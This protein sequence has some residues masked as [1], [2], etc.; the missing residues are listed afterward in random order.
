MTNAANNPLHPKALRYL[1]A[2]AQLGSVQA[3]ARE[4]SI[5]ASAIDRQILL[6]EQDLGVPLFERLPR[7]MRPTAAGE[8][9]LALSQRWK[10]DLNRTLSDI[11][12][13]QG[14]NQGQLR[15][16][17]MDSHANGLL[18]EFVHTVHTEYPGVELD[19]EIVNTDDAV[20]HL[21]AGDV[22]LL[23][24]FNL[25]ASRDLHIVATADLPL[26]CV[27]APQHPLASQPHLSFRD[28]AAWPLAAQSRALAIRRYLDR[29]HHWLLE[30]ARPPLVTNS[31]QLVKRLACSGTHVALTSELDAGPEILDGSLRFVPVL[32]KSALAQTVAVAIS[33][34]RPLSRVARIVAERLGQHVI[35]YLARVRALTQPDTKRK[36]AT[37]R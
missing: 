24:A 2:V 1:S 37:P 31:L 29:R 30:E 18:P 10:A 12:Q 21:L 13:L 32:D 36:K 14:V 4:V 23:V 5:S 35:D 19:V 25:K 17:A 15:I 3:A 9:L 26:G 16:A 6:L 34:N 28:V 20:R 27:M 33:A 22:D 8:L 7:G 11:Q